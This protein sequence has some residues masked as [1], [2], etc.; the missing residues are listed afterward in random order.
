MRNQKKLN[1]LY[2]FLDKAYHLK[3]AMRKRKLALKVLLHSLHITTWTIV[4]GIVFLILSSLVIRHIIVKSSSPLK[5]F[6][7]QA[8]FLSDERL[9]AVTR[10]HIYSYDIQNKLVSPPIYYTSKGEEIIQIASPLLNKDKNIL[11]FF[12]RNLRKFNKKYLCYLNLDTY[13][14]TKIEIPNV[15]LDSNFLDDGKTL[16]LNFGSNKVWF[17]SP[18]KKEKYNLNFD[19]FRAVAL[20]KTKVFLL[21]KDKQLW[22]DLEKEEI[23]KIQTIGLKNIYEPFLEI[24]SNNDYLLTFNS[25]NLNVSSLE[26]SEANKNFMILD[27]NPENSKLALR[28]DGK[29]V[30]VYNDDTILLL[31]ADTM[32][33]IWQIQFPGGING[34]NS[35]EFSKDGNLLLVGGSVSGQIGSVFIYK[36]E[37]GQFYRRALGAND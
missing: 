9:L 34:P 27:L 12:E 25:R 11:V 8:L 32:E 17:V 35:L 14:M 19:G 10:F 6:R 4:F 18:D 36:V 30:A 28:E 33:R 1:N 21:F 26:Q 24:S 37:N 16:F 29:L 15:P 2:K 20:D 3:P 5:H 7:K 23:L 22:Y 31:R 13:E